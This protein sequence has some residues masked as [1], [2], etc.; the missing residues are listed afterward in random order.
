MSAGRRL[1]PPASLESSRRRFEEDL[2]ALPVSL[3]DLDAA[4]PP[5]PKI[6][7][8]LGALAEEAIATATR[9]GGS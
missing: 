5:V 8:A 4:T 2:D 7:S 1:R 3:R 9:A 6:S